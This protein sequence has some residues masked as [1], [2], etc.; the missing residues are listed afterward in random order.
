MRRARHDCIVVGAGPAGCASAM[1]LARWGR[2]VLLV[3]DG[4]GTNHVFEETILDGA[5]PRL[6]AMGLGRIIEEPEWQGTSEHAV[7]WGSDELRLR[8]QPQGRHPGLKVNRKAFDERLRT[9]A[10]AAGAKEVEARV[11]SIQGTEPPHIVTTAGVLSA[12]TIICCTGRRTTSRLLSMHEKTVGP[13]TVAMTAL[14]PLNESDRD[15]TLIEA[16]RDGWFWRLP[17]GDGQLAITLF[18]DLQTTRDGNRDTWNRA[19]RDAISWPRNTT[20]LPTATTVFVPRLRAGPDGVFLAGDAASSADPLSSQG[21]EKALFSAEEAAYAANTA[22]ETTISKSDLNGHLQHHE[23][24]LFELHKRQTAEWYRRETR[25]EDAPFW[26]TR[27]TATEVND[28]PGPLPS[29][30][31]KTPNLSTA[32]ILVRENCVLTPLDGYTSGTHAP[33]AR[34]GPHGVSTLL[35]LFEHPQTLQGA[36]ALASKNP[37]HVAFRP[38]TLRSACRTLFEFGLIKD[39]SAQQDAQ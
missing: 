19:C 15:R 23:H 29:L 8:E 37:M 28:A 36:G 7:I 5:F 17:R 31:V 33:I 30:M 35:E 3:H 10:I 18:A 21:I 32:Q 12:Q 38:S 4:Q 22:L 20:F 14:S 1:T 16:V 27:Q 39:A 6:S 34:I 26:K 2:N 24:G 9:E 13:L 11:L 25:F